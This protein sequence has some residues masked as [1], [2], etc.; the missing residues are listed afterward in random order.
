MLQDCGLYLVEPLPQSELQQLEVCSMLSVSLKID[1][2]CH[3]RKQMM[4][5][6]CVI[7]YSLLPAPKNLTWNVQECILRTTYSSE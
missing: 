2:S 5:L 1:T 7:H 4:L 6:C 3:T